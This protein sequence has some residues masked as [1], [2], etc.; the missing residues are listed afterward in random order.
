[1]TSTQLLT[2]LKE[3]ANNYDAVL[4]DA[5]GVIHNG[6]DLFPEV[7]DAL[8]TFRRER[9]PVIILTNAPRP[10]TVIPGQLDRIG[11]ARDA[12]DGI[13]TSGDSTC[14]AISKFLPAPAFRIG[15]EKDDPLFENLAIRFEELEGARFIICTGLVD[16]QSEEP[17]DYRAMLKRAVER[18]LPM[19]CANPDIVVNWGGRLVWCAGALAQIYAELGGQ[20]IYG[21][22]PFTPIYE[23]A[24]A[25]IDEYRGAPT[26]TSRILAIG[27]GLKTDIAGANAHDIDALYIAGDGGIHSGG[28]GG[29]DLSSLFAEAGVNVI[30]TMTGLRW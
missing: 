25:Q 7:A 12:W 26:P 8:I 28:V 23:L 6:V 15:P 10:S 2:G 30:A 21:G 24:M 3:I 22:K 5:W 29:D 13:V 27:D 17:E 9:G 20:V 18:N 1:M 19:V 16:D 11:L 4:C 14:A